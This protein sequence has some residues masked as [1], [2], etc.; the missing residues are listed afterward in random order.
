M[1]AVRGLASNLAWS[2]YGKGR[3]FLG[4]PFLYLA[5]TGVPLLLVGRDHEV[6][7]A[8]E[9]RQLL[10]L[11]AEPKHARRD[12]SRLGRQDDVRS[13]VADRTNDGLRCRDSQALLAHAAALMLGRLNMRRVGAG[14]GSP[15]PRW[16]STYSSIARR[17]CS[18]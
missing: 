5:P 15:L 12:V 8:V 16:R 13:E 9:D 14:A 18:C 1:N 10:A 2:A 4:R 11:T 3:L 17:M 7:V 6:E